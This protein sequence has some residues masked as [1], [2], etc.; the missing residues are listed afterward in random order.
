MGVEGVTA[1][2]FDSFD[3]EVEFSGLPESE[4][5]LMLVNL[6]HSEFSPLWATLKCLATLTGGGVSTSIVFSH[7]KPTMR[8][9]PLE[10]NV[11]DHRKRLSMLPIKGTIFL[12]VQGYFP[13]FFVQKQSSFKTALLLSL[14]LG[15]VMGGARVGAFG[16]VNVKRGVCGIAVIELTVSGATKASLL[17]SATSAFNSFRFLSLISEIFQSKRLLAPSCSFKLAIN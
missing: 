7:G 15:G 2:G 8:I 14:L 4:L 10:V 12:V 13:K 17:S 16:G 3:E 1:L 11:W 9:F 5:L 6:L